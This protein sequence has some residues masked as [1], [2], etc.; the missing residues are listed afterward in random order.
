MWVLFLFLWMLILPKNIWQNEVFIFG[1]DSSPRD[2]ALGKMASVLEQ[3]LYSGVVIRLLMGCFSAMAVWGF[4][5]S[6]RSANGIASLPV[7]RE[8][9][10][11]SIYLGGLLP[12]LCIYLT[13]FAAG[14]FAA[15]GTDLMMPGLL[16]QW[17]A[18]ESLSFFF[19]YSFASLCAMLTGSKVTL[20]LLYLAL[21]F[22]AICVGYIV[23][24]LFT[25][26]HY[27]IISDLSLDG[28]IFSF[29][30]P[31]AAFF[32]YIDVRP[33]TDE[34]IAITGWG[35]LWTYAAAAVVMLIGAMLLFRRRRMESAGE[36][37]AVKGLKPVFRWV[38]MIGF[39][40]VFSIIMSGVHLSINGLVHGRYWFIGRKAYLMAAY[41][42]IGAFLGWMI[43]EMRLQ[44]SFRIF[45]TGQWTTFCLG[46]LMIAVIMLAVRFDLTGVVRRVPEAKKV[47][48]VTLTYGDQKA[49]LTN[50][51]D[52]EQA[53]ELHRAFIGNKDKIEA[54]GSL[55]KTQRVVFEYIYASCRISYTL[56]DGSVFERQYPLLYTVDDWEEWPEAALMDELFNC[57]EAMRTRTE[58]LLTPDLTGKETIRVY[59][60]MTANECAAAS[61]Y[62]D[63]EEYILSIEKNSGIVGEERQD[64]IMR[65]IYDVRYDDPCLYVT[66]RLNPSVLAY[67]D[68]DYDKTWF[69]YDFPGNRESKGELWDAMCRDIE[70]GTLGY[71]A[72][73]DNTMYRTGSYLAYLDMN[74][75]VGEEDTNR[76]NRSDYRYITFPITT[77]A[78]HTI[79]YLESQ[80]IRLH[81]PE[82]VL[83]Q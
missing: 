11:L 55:V 50:D 56:K 40:L 32:R 42:L 25:D 18:V 51:A 45:R 62:E 58:F 38:M 47:K 59:A 72:L 43:A 15:Y 64:S 31:A 6:K 19:F 20:P 67:E 1:Q 54:N 49:V 30:T 46:A 22:I 10:F 60:V 63:V 71:S 39:A 36:V 33:I 76:N 12:A 2:L 41:L 21:N 70:E 69:R 66:Y 73:L 35:T 16:F 74:V 13:V 52:F 17:F 29:L 75:K 37:T 27:G 81:T 24:T 44:K 57:P 5:Y 61:S 34:R 53:L 79:D 48:S 7:R 82:E 23:N 9:L 68:L 4:L 3:A 77:S 28:G 78:R 83:G 14:C 8:S 26:L 80:G 65:R